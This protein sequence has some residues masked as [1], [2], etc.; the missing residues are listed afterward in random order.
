[1]NDFYSRYIRHIILPGFGIKGQDFL[2]KSKVLCIGAGGLGS[3][4]LMYLASA[5]VG[6]IGIVDFDVVDASNLNRQVIF[7]LSD[8]GKSKAI[9]A[10]NYVLNLNSHVDINVYNIK[11]S[12]INCFRIIKDYDVVLDCTDN[13]ESKFFINDAVVKMG[14]PLIHGAVSNLEGYVAVFLKK[15]GCYR[16]LYSNFIGLECLSNGIVGPIPGIIGSI[17][18]LEAIKILLNSNNNF[19]NLISRLLMLDFKTFDFKLLHIKRKKNCNICS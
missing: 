2:K 15:F 5:G 6:T 16:C 1:M 7:N 19:L 8:I 3:T 10:K 18:A 9:C 17:Q 4:A 13:L 11:L 12:Y 14:L